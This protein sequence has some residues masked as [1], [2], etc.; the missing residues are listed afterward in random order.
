MLRL[1]LQAEVSPPLTLTWSSDNITSAAINQM[2][3][4]IIGDDAADA[5]LVASDGTVTQISLMSVE[6]LNSVAIND[7]G[8][9]LIGGEGSALP[10]AAFVVDGTAT[11]I[12]GTPSMTGG[13]LLSVA[14]NSSG[15]GIIGGLLVGT[16]SYGALVFANG[17]PLIALSPLP[18]TA[19]A[20]LSGVAIN[21]LGLGL[22]GG[23]DGYGNAFAGYA[24]TDG[25]V[26]PLFESPFA[27]S[28]QSVSINSSGTGLIGGADN[29]D[30][31]AAFVQ[32]DGTVTPL[33]SDPIAGGISS[34]AINDA[35][36]GLIGGQLGTTEGYAALVAPNGTLTSLD[37][38]ETSI[39]NSVALGN[40]TSSVTPQSIGPFLSTVYTQLAA[41][42]ALESRFIQRNRIWNQARGSEVAENE[43]L[44]CNDMELA[45]GSAPKK[46]NPPPL[47]NQNAIWV[48]PFGDYVH[49]KAQGAI[50]NYTNAVS[51]ALIGYDYQFS[52]ALVGASLGYAFNYVHY[53]N[54]LGHGKVQEEMANIYGSYFQDHFRCNAA[55]WGGIYQFWNT[56]H[57]L[58]IITSEAM[59][60]GWILSPH[61]ELAT[62]W[63]I[64]Q[65]QRYFVE[66]FAMFD[67]VNSWQNHFTESGAAGF[68]LNM[69]HHYGSLLQSEVGLRFYQ[70]FPY[71]WGNFNLEEKASYVN[72]A[73]FQF[74]SVTT[75]FVGATST[76][77]IAVASTKVENL[78]ALQLV[79]SFVPQDS[80]YSGGFSLQAT[81][82][83]SYQSYFAS[84][85]G[86]WNF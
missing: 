61:I 35:G 71:G 82:N 29:D 41:I 21:D 86:S 34:V 17:D 65:N 67:W 5:A 81:A 23:V 13:Q 55:L 16:S 50:P 30:L 20:Q 27:G 78:A 18:S 15:N 63:A 62:P 77:P 3:N 31:Y 58:S 68:N 32:Q 83:G 47:L 10:Y 24:A 40:L 54:S 44:V 39:I 66:P 6:M 48:A 19:Y 79:G 36:V 33:F 59:T 52:N 28:I 74:N 57:T 80:A 53:S 22:V 37:V 49:L 69:G 42:S 85:F 4:G 25:T 84:L 72:Q 14:L 1:Y 26:T 38:S 46:R 70:Q 64:D 7:D 51:G 8:V 45:L 73:P 56:R 60:H 75:S 43:L 2:G 12:S 76:F 9:G 11:Q